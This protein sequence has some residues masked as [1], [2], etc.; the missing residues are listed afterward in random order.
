MTTRIYCDFP[1]CTEWV[2]YGG[3]HRGFCVVQVYP[4]SGG[5]DLSRHYACRIHARN[6]ESLFRND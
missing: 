4:I 3:D 5:S 6:V 1:E 2:Q